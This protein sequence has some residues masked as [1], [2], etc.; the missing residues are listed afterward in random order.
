MTNVNIFRLLTNNSYI[1]SERINNII[2][3]FL[4]LFV[5]FFIALCFETF[6]LLI[7]LEFLKNLVDRSTIQELFQILKIYLVVIFDC[8]HLFI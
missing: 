6:L 1:L 5:V 4:F 8:C 2:N 3:C 7:E